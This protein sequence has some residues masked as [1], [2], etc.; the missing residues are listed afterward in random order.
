MNEQE[1]ARVVG[2][3]IRGVEP[4]D[5]DVRRR[6]LWLLEWDGTMDVLRRAALAGGD[7]RSLVQ[8]LRC[9]ALVTASAVMLEN[10]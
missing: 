7:R 10:R 4:E 1:W 6:V 3:V 9:L 8:I 2:D 5:A